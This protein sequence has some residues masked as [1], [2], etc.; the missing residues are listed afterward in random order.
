MS[1]GKDARG[2]EFCNERHAALEKALELAAKTQDLR[3][4]HLEASVRDFKAFMVTQVV[5][6]LLAGVSIAIALLKH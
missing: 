4:A 6:W 3:M 5:A 1:D 2:S